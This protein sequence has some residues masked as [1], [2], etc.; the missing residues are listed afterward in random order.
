MA[1]SEYDDGIDI[2]RLKLLERGHIH[3]RTYF[4]IDMRSE[5]ADGRF[6]GC[7]CRVRSEEIRKKGSQFFRIIRI[8]SSGMRSCTHGLCG[9]CHILLFADLAVAC[10][11]QEKILVKSGHDAEQLIGV[12]MRVRRFED[13]LLKDADTSDPVE[14][15][16]Q[17]PGLRFECEHLLGISGWIAKKQQILTV[18]L[19]HLYVE[20]MPQ[21]RNGRLER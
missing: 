2:T 6:L 9:V 19:D 15:R 16:K 1:G 14:Q 21:T 12:D 10:I 18:I 5:Y 20:I 7:R 8:G 13:L 11:I 3:L 4:Q 17:C